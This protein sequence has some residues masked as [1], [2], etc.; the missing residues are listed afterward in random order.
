LKG[1]RVSSRIWLLVLVLTPFAA[2]AATS[3]GTRPAE[4]IVDSVRIVGLPRPLASA[5]EDGL[6]LS[7][8][9]GFLGLFG[10]PGFEPGLLEEDL[11]RIRLFLARH[12]YPDARI[13][14]RVE[15]L[16]GGRRVIVV[17]DIDPGEVIR[18]HSVQVDSLPP[19]AAAQGFLS[20]AHT[21][22]GS[23]LI[24]EQVQSDRRSIVRRLQDLG[25]AHA[26][27]TVRLSA[28]GEHAVDLRF[29]VEPGPRFR[30]GRLRIRGPSPDLVPMVRR[31]VKLDPG[32]LYSRDLVENLDWQLR[33][34]NLFRR[35][36]LS[37]VE[38][39][40]TT[41]D[42]HYELLER[43]PRTIELGVGY[44][45]DEAFRVTASWQH[46]NLFRKGRGL[47]VSG[48]YSGIESYLNASAWWPAIFST[49]NTA[50]LGL[51]YRVEDE[52]SYY[53][54]ENRLSLFSSWRPRR[55]TSLNYGIVT[56]QLDLDDK[57]GGDDP[58][59]DSRGWITQLFGSWSHD[60]RD[61]W[62][63]ARTGNTMTLRADLTPPGLGSIQHAAHAE[64]GLS[65]THTL[66]GRV[67]VALKGWVGSAV[68]LFGSDDLLIS[69]RVFSG[70]ARS[71]RG[72]RR[73]R[74]GPKDPEGKPLGGEVKYE[75]SAELRFPLWKSVEGAVFLDNGQLWRRWNSL[76]DGGVEWAVGP[77]LALKTP[78]GPLRIDYAI[79][80]S[81]RG[82]GEPNEVLHFSVGH[83]Y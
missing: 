26:R 35:I 70:G 83:P 2:G 61:D 32:V 82:D 31:V 23:P 16:P 50:V 71:M 29:L 77:G 52:I 66:H 9:S 56:S 57:T 19:P 64:I 28:A 45:T 14:P 42:F 79:R 13:R 74:L 68:P 81:S 48:V 27:V 10:R 7:E 60:R 3:A 15:P 36:Q 75:A 17:F 33:Q 65:T 69:Q 22:A 51:S 78:V 4:P 62:L 80:L 53:Q 11:Q 72:Y 38:A 12:G 44:F 6:A 46:R 39:D 58:R 67:R 55:R 18:V 24:D 63:D 54:T 59:D 37:V 47:K 41:L 5:L 8:K 20:P 1:V 76:F 25:Y 73:R 43:D 21:L 34:L 40:S 49:A 30:V